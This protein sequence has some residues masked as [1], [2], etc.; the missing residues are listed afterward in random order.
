MET[1]GSLHTEVIVHGE[2]W[3]TGQIRE[4][5]GTWWVQ[6]YRL[7][8]YGHGPE[9]RVV[10][11]H[12]HDPRS[13]VGVRSTDQRSK[14]KHIICWGGKREADQWK[15]CHSSE[16]KNCLS[17]DQFCQQLQWYSWEYTLI[18]AIQK[19]NGGN[20]WCRVLNPRISTMFSTHS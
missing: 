7:D 2:Q 13:I 8:F 15:I 17:V 12:S 4:G 3:T 16:K 18:D 11:F 5:R 9:K 6:P 10:S 1:F 20:T 14:G 19:Q